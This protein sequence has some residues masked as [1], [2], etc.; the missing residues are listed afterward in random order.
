MCKKC[1]DSIKG[2]VTLAEIQSAREG[3]HDLTLIDNCQ[4]F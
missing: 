3:S 2:V 4:T 1:R